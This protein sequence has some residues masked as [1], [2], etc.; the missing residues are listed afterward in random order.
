[1]G[2]VA[3][4]CA[5]PPPGSPALSP[6]S[7]VPGRRLYVAFHGFDE[8]DSA[9][10]D[11]SDEWNW[12]AAPADGVPPPPP[13]PGAWRQGL[14]KPADGQP[15]GFGSSLRQLASATGAGARENRLSLFPDTRLLGTPMQFGPITA[16]GT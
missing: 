2:A 7:A 14:K 12:A 9:W 11:D 10:I 16:R 6:H 4:F 15:E 8:A 1:M 5:Q 13:V 3:P